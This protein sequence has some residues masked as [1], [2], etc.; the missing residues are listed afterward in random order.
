M[1]IDWTGDLVG[2]QSGDIYMVGAMPSAQASSTRLYKLP[3]T[4]QVNGVS[5]ELI[6]VAGAD[7]TSVDSVFYSSDYFS[8]A[9]MT[10]TG[11][12]IAVGTTTKTYLFQRQKWH[13]VARAFVSACVKTLGFNGAVLSA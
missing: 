4:D 3:V 2:G 10:T 8:R 5:S 1:F 11:D 6:V 12:V 7:T 9:D 13:S